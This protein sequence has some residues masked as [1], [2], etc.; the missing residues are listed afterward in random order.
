MKILQ[1]NK[2]FFE[3]Y[4]IEKYMF[5]LFELLQKREHKIIHFST[6]DARNRPSPQ[7]KYF[8]DKDDL[9]RAKI[10]WRSLRNFLRIIYNRSARIKFAALLDQEKPDI[11]HLHSIHHQL[12]PSILK[13]SKKR[14]I[15]VVQTL[16]DYKL[17]TP[18]YHFPWRA[19]QVCLKCRRGKWL[20]LLR[21]KAHKN[22]YLAT[23][24]VII[25]SAIHSW[26]HVYEK[27]IDHFIVPSPDM[28]KRLIRSGFSPEKITTVP[29]FLNNK[30]KAADPTKGIGEGILFAGRLAPERGLGHLLYFAQR[31]PD[32]N[33]YVAGDGPERD[34]LENKI[35]ILGLK[36]VFLLGRLN[37][38]NLY[39][40]Y[41]K[42]RLVIYPTQTLETFGLTVLEAA[43]HGRPVVACAL[44]GVKDLIESGVNGFLYAPD[45]PEQGLTLI[46]KLLQNDDLD[47]WMGAQGKKMAARYNKDNHLESITQIYNKL[48]A[49]KQ[50]TDQK[51]ARPIN[52]PTGY[53]MAIMGHRGI[54]GNYGGFETFAEELAVR[55]AKKRHHVQVYCRPNYGSYKKNIYKGVELIHLK[56]VANK[57]LDTIVHTFKSVLHAVFIARPQV[58]IMTNVGNAMLSFIPRIFGIPVILNVDGLEWQ[59]KKWGRLAKI[60]L[61]LQA[62]LTRFLPSAVVTDAKVIFDFYKDRLGIK[63]HMIPYGASI[64][65]QDNPDVL[66]KYGLKKDDYYL[67]VARFE[68]E[69]NAHLVVKAFEQVASDKKLV[70]VG[71]APYANQYCRL[72]R[73]TKDPRIKFLGFV[74]GSDYKALQ[75]NAYAYIQA[76][77]VGGTH[78]ALIEALGFGNCVLVNGTPENM[79][80]T[81]GSAIPF[82]F[83]KS[84]PATKGLTKKIQMIE[85]KPEMVLR[86]RDLAQKHIQKNYRWQTVT[87]QYL[88]IVY[89]LVDRKTILG[90]VK[91]KHA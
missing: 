17:L 23:L 35:K 38:T 41:Q 15:P 5:D 40:M 49:T 82:W 14:G 88:S 12:S 20:H 56:T 28:R 6:K 18:V 50:K 3:E 43:A 57:Y 55:L 70:M 60:Y 42:A 31:L 29:H 72:V 74:Y 27:N 87:D 51:I 2:F 33:F 78:P 10:S 58:I 44:G 73:N 59:R 34:S 69:N 68:P 76:T 32:Q 46:E 81:N 64:K 39:R 19:G 37:Q 48:L 86:Y 26:T 91:S 67:Y 66:K 53:R 47:I 71:D 80:T 77:E 21:H 85:D 54:P 84:K 22:S 4:G 52:R 9:S 83:F 75:Q 61:R 7:S 25:E 63:S 8:V 65:R 89:Q 13:E 11:I 1:V 79:E 16:H 45:K 90:V 24:A 30:I 62:S 36:N